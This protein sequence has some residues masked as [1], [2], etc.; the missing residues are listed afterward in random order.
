MS[1]YETLHPSPRRRPLSSFAP[2]T[3]DFAPRQVPHPWNPLEIAMI[4]AA[5]PPSAAR[6]SLLANSA[7]GSLPLLSHGFSFLTTGNPH[8][9][10]LFDP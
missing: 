6:R 5:P 1:M 9:F 10:W 2:K 4:S 7:G 8:H 3:T